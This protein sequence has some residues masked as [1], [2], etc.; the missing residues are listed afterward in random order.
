MRL[1]MVEACRN[2][3]PTD[4]GRFRIMA[5][6]GVG[7][8]GTVYAARAR[9]RPDEL[10]AVKVV[11]ASLASSPDFRSRFARETAAI[12][13]VDSDFVPRLIDEGAAEDPAWLAT[14]LIPGL[15]LDR[16]VRACGPMPE[17]AVW[18]L[19]AGIAEALASIHQAGLVHRDL[20][21]HNVLLVPGRPWVIDF[22]L[23]HLTELPHQSSSRF[24]MATYKYAA[25]EQLQDGLKAAGVRADVFALGATLLFAATG[26]PPHEA[27]SLPELFI[28]AQTAKPNLAGLPQGLYHLV[29]RC[30]HR[31]PDARLPLAELRAE[32]DRRVGRRHPG[33]FAADLPP[34][35]TKMLESYRGELASVMQA[36]GPERL[37]WARPRPDR[38]S[39]TEP[40]PLPSFDEVGGLAA[41]VSSVTTKLASR[42][43]VHHAP[44]GNTLDWT[45]PGDAWI[46]APVAVLGDNA[47][48]ASLDGTVRF[49][50]VSLRQ[51]R[52]CGPVR[53]QAPVHSAPLL[54]PGGAG[55][56]G[57][58]YVGAADG[59]VHA[60]DVASGRHSLFYRATAGVHCS[61][62][63]VGD[64]MYILS[65]DGNLH[66]IHAHTRASAIVFRAGRPAAGALSAGAGL[67]FVTSTDGCVQA[68]DAATHEKRWRLAT[69]G[70]VL[71]APLPVTDLLY[72]A[73]TDG[74]VRQ[75][76]IRDGHE[77]EPFKIDV[78]VHAAPAY[79]RRH[80]YIG[81]S[82]GR[83][84]AYDVTSRHRGQDPLWT[85]ELGEEIAG[86]AAAHGMVYVTAGR[87]LMAIDAMTGQAHQ[88]L[89]GNSL[90]T[91][92]PTISSGLGY[93]AS[94]GGEVTCLVLRLSGSTRIRPGRA[95]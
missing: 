24:P 42:A 3:D 72:V 66:A 25:P 30:L 21:P 31:F 28:Q 87:R 70:L 89:E 51:E 10:A 23:V 2:G 16:I 74:L 78:P 82:D 17:P 65:L 47:A 49:L 27:E 18:R 7:G 8:F 15:S 46:R 85:R 52:S 5:H 94:L 11:H 93:V 88:R 9:N 36:S 57:V 56:E 60:I 6:L 59:T 40:N 53:I 86:L 76:S 73:G 48:V 45:L 79:D 77:L 54:L 22:G 69:D 37:G 62:V 58:A 19:G 55:G 84:H 61:P 35:V 64:Y 83:V 33:S 4:I 63:V 43:H 67:I 90:L 32:F 26:H 92:A 12:K 13:R 34:D 68:V 71:S 14:E 95:R 91:A 29:E 39:P 80:L 44:A 38:E 75:V 81:G 20:K 41:E 1:P 50:H